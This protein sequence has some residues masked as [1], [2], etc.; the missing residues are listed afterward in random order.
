L[1]N[2]I[3]ERAWR[4]LFGGRTAIEIAV[5]INAFW[6]DPA[7]KII[8]LKSDG[9]KAETINFIPP[10]NKKNQNQH[11]RRPRS[12]GG[13]SGGQNKIWVNRDEHAA[14]HY[15]FRNFTG[16]EIAEKI[17]RK[18]LFNSDYRFKTVFLTGAE[19]GDEADKKSPFYCEVCEK[20]YFYEVEARKCREKGWRAPRFGRGE[21]VLIKIKGYPLQIGVIIDWDDA[22]S[23]NL[24]FYEK[25][26]VEY[27]DGKT[28]SVDVERI[29][30]VLKNDGRKERRK[31]IVVFSKKA[32]KKI[33]KRKGFF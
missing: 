11:H 15:L 4:R 28:G 5:I 26:T 17:N 29:K 25:Y 23:L 33:K 13:K 9:T 12:I 14:W 2:N 16:P 6:L 32:L 31:K 21:K 8:V 22:F 30:Y 20:P 1:E 19:T 7:Y 18:F 10:E 24:H 27:N 3:D